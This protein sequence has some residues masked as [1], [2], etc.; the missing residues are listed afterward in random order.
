MIERCDETIPSVLWIL[1]MWGTLTQWLRVCL[2]VANAGMLSSMLET[3]YWGLVEDRNMRF[4][5]LWR[6][7]MCIC[8][9]SKR[10][11]IHSAECNCEC[12][13]RTP[14]TVWSTLRVGW[15]GCDFLRMRGNH[16]KVGLYGTT[17]T[18][19]PL[20]HLSFNSTRGMA[21]WGGNR[22]N[23][24]VGELVP[25]YCEGIMATALGWAKGATD[26]GQL[27]VPR[28]REE[29]HFERTELSVKELEA[30]VVQLPLRVYRGVSGQLICHD[31]VMTWDVKCC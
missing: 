6:V 24:Y 27:V 31:I 11:A 28:G 21:F 19:W 1:E 16:G 7:K 5:D 14:L 13:T 4:C 29:Y 23:V 22:Y 26:F 25:V 20:Y 2:L 9:L 17:I 30:V 12:C 8:H 18:P 10:K 15:R 3:G